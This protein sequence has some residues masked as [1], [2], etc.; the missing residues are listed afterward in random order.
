M[1]QAEVSE[2]LQLRSEELSFMN[3]GKSRQCV[4]PPPRF[5]A[6]SCETRPFIFDKISFLRFIQIIFV[7]KWPLAFRVTLCNKMSY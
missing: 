4:K 7:F 3:T 1:S 6:Q 2:N 5:R